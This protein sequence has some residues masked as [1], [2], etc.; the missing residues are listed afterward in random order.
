MHCAARHLILP[1]HVRHAFARENR[2]HS[3]RSLKYHF[4]TLAIFA[5]ATFPLWRFPRY[6]DEL[7]QYLRLIQLN[8]EQLMNRTL[9]DLRFE[10]KQTD[11]NELMVLD[12]L[13]DAC[14]ATI[15]GYPTTVRD[16][17]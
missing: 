9:E 12:S 5:F 17:S 3:G 15:A 14:T 4:C 10:R 7:L 8:K 1:S 6:P 11:V 16:A 2:Y 13:V